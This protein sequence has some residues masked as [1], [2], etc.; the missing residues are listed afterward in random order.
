MVAEFVRKVV[1]IALLVVPGFQLAVARRSCGFFQ[2]LILPH[3]DLPDLQA[4]RIRE[5][6]VSETGFH[7]AKQ[8]PRVGGAVTCCNA[9][10]LSEI[11]SREMCNVP[12]PREAL[13]IGTILR[14]LRHLT[15]PILISVRTIL[16]GIFELNCVETFYVN[17]AFDLCRVRI[18]VP[19][20]DALEVI[21]LL[22]DI[23]SVIPIYFL[24]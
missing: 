13:I 17:A 3:N 21:W 2:E 6:N 19:H 8:N 20:D 9:E 18:S 4:F 7:G 10:L 23:L 24:K 22:E 5:A 11:G 1:P 14:R 16:N 12:A 15:T